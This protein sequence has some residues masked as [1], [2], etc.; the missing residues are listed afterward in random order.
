MGEQT[1]ILSGPY[2]NAQVCAHKAWHRAHMHNV[3]AL[4]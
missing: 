2:S 1:L 4:P 3:S